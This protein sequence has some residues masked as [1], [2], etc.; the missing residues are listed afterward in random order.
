MQDNKKNTITCNY[1]GSEVEN[2][3]VACPYCG[4]PLQPEGQDETLQPDYMPLSE[5]QSYDDQEQGK[6]WLI[7]LSIAAG[8]IFMPPASKSKHLNI[9]KIHYP[10]I[11]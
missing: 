4:A 2:S 5:E 10:S 8:G 6:R 9:Y 1:C 3:H 7:S 11:K